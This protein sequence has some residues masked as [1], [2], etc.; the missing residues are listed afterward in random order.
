MYG[1]LIMGI[2]YVFYEELIIDLL[3]GCIL[4]VDMEFYWF[5]FF[6]DVGE[7][8]VYLMSGLGYDECGV[9]GFGEFLVI[10]LGVVISNVV[11]NVIGVRVLYLLIMF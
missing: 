3:S 8:D 1:G 11:V 6:M 10:F 7:F 9:I 4:N 5:V 2:G